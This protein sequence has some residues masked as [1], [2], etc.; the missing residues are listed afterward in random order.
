VSSNA[1]LGNVQ[2]HVWAPALAKKVLARSCVSARHVLYAPENI[3]CSNGGLLIRLQLRVSLSHTGL[4]NSAVDGRPKIA[5]TLKDQFLLADAY[6]AVSANRNLLPCGVVFLSAYFGHM[7]LWSHQQKSLLHLS[8]APDEGFGHLQT[9]A[10]VEREASD[11]VR[12]LINHEADTRLTNSSL[13][14]LM[15]STQSEYD[16]FG[17]SLV[18]GIRLVATD[19]RYIGETCGI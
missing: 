16:I 5:M 13:V 2:G 4:K 14:L 8:S 12:T 15:K 3:L 17:H 6:H 1:F 11:S 18:S 19:L 9:S 10:R 7:K